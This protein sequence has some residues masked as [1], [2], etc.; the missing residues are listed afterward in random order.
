[1]D[2]KRLKYFCAIIDHGQISK[3]A[4]ALHIAQPALSMRLKE[5]EQDLNTTLVYRQGRNWQVTPAGRVLYQRAQELITQAENI[6]SEVEDAKHE[7]DTRLTIGASSIR[8]HQLAN[9]IV[10]TIAVYPKLKFRLYYGDIFYLENLLDS[11][12]IDLAVYHCINEKKP[13]YEYVALQESSYSVVAPVGFLKQTQKCSVHALEGIPLV[14]P[15]RSMGGGVHQLLLQKFRERKQHANIVIDG[16]DVQTLIYF[17]RSG[18]QA[19]LLLPTSEVTNECEKEFDVFILDD[20]D[21]KVCPY[22][23]YRKNQYIDKAM[24]SL[25]EILASEGIS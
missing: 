10:K 25:I 9:S 23:V 24:S 8:F 17:L 11:K 21:F 18:L 19:A 13:H 5:L 20:T 15:R 6:L 14:V 22:I 12:L 7:Y 4:K 1:M 2:L 3:A 16:Q